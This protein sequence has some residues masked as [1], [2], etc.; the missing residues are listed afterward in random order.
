VLLGL[1]G[2][3]WGV[4]VRNR[5]WHTE[6][7]LWQDDVEK[8]PHNG[9]GQM[10]YGLTLMGKGA[11]PQA[12][13]YF[14]RALQY[15]P[16][17]STLEINLGVVNGAMH[18][19]AEAERHFLRA[20]ALTP[21]DDQ[22]H[23]YYGRWL[24]QTG[25]LQQAIAQLKMA[26]A[27]NSARPFAHEQLLAVYSQ[28]G[29]AGA[30]RAAALATLQ[31]VP[32]DPVAQAMLTY[33][34]APQTASWINMSLDQYRQGEYRQSIDTARRALQLDPNSAEAYNNIG[35]SYGAMQ[36][37]DVAIQNER[38]ALRLRPDLQIA[39]NNLALFRQKKMADGTTPE[40]NA[41]VAELIDRSLALNQSGKYRE[42]IA[43]AQAALQIDPGSAEAWNNIAAGDE[44]LHRWNAAIVAAHKALALQP[45]FQLAKNN[46]AWSQQQLRQ[47]AHH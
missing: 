33:A 21:D 14:E 23:A 18:R 28:M 13:G 34:P 9:R 37:W 2:Y 44:A 24:A 40:A 43:A 8:S 26:I 25:R 19:D 4:H 11:Y 46:L 7:S 31:A 20:I 47:A 5:V 3:A 16:N 39:K 27:L 22:P 38:E 41:S 6:D 10:I 12:L 45:D 42:S 36:Q 29:D 15:T 30:L 32:D 35:A 1:S 17:Y